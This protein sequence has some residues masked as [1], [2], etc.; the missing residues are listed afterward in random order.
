MPLLKVYKKGQGVY[1]RVTVGAVLGI[2]NLFV[3]VSLFNA[4]IGLPNIAGNAKI[5]LIDIDLTWGFVSA[6]VLFVV[7]GFFI[8]VFAAGFDTGIRMLDAGGKKTVD[9]LIDIQSELQKVSWPTR[10]EL[11]GS[12]AVVI[13][14]VIVIGVYILGVDWI[15]SR[16]MEYVGV[17]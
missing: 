6:T 15:V 3:S 10:Y 13:V 7:S 4:L 2:L 17:L 11:I 8:G 5:P 16:I 9:F 14:S 1:S 12:T